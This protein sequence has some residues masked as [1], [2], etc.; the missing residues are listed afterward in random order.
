M[1]SEYES[2]LVKEFIFLIFNK[3]APINKS[4]FGDHRVYFVFDSKNFYDRFISLAREID[5]HFENVI[6]NRMELFS[7]YGFSVSVN[8]LLYNGSIVAAISYR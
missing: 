1:Q 2:K 5:Q 6:K 3:A 4:E 8:Q 7:V